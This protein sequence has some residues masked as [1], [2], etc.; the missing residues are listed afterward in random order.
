MQWYVESKDEVDDDEEIDDLDRDPD[1]VLSDEE[2]T[3]QERNVENDNGS[4]S[5]DSEDD[6]LSVQTTMEKCTAFVKYGIKIQCLDDSATS[7]LFNAYIY[8][9]RDSDGIG[10]SEEERKL[11]KPTQST[12][13][14]CKP[15][16]G[17]KRNVTG[18]NWFSSLELVEELRKRSL[19]YVGTYY[20]KNQTI[21]S[22]ELKENKSRPV[23]SACYGF[24]SDVPVTLL[25]I[26]PKINKAVVLI[27][28][29]HD[30]PETD[31]DKNKPEIAKN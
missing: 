30:K 7:Y 10:L 16:E 1:Y 23:G 19:T 14:L 21:T 27:S 9:G 24:A 8:T 17:S 5:S 2:Q 12:I 26:V 20:K 15:L 28:S 4:M 22:P 31:S 6:L 13:R 25:S 18:D 11:S 3:T 29:M